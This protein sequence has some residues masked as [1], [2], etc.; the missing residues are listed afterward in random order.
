MP[1]RNCQIYPLYSQ[2]NHNRDLLVIFCI[3]SLA[4]AWCGSVRLRLHFDPRNVAILL[5]TENVSQF[6][7]YW[8]LNADELSVIDQNAN[9]LIYDLLETDDEL[10]THMEATNKFMDAQLSHLRGLASRRDRNEHLL[11]M[12]RRWSVYNFKQFIECL[13]KTQRHLV[14]LLTGET[15]YSLYF[16]F[17]SDLPNFHEQPFIANISTE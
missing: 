4:A 9:R 16:H 11:D 17:C 10:L 8:P 6:E 5:N 15:G 3:R 13:S 14:P 7:G 1:T 2:V 12:L